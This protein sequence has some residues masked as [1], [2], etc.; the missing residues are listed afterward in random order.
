MSV[1]MTSEAAGAAFIAGE[2]AALQVFGPT[3]LDRDH[4]RAWWLGFLSALRRRGAVS[5]A[6]RFGPAVV[7]LRLEGGDE[8]L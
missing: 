5:D 3:Y 7:P 1:P 2:Q 6:L 4:E 8:N